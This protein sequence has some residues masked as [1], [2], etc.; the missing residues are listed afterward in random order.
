M[1]KQGKKQRAARKNKKKPKKREACFDMN[2][3]EP[4]RNCNPKLNVTDLGS[5]SN[6]CEKN[7]ES[8][9]DDD[10]NQLKR[11]QNN[12]KVISDQSGGSEEVHNHQNESAKEL[13]VPANISNDHSANKKGLRPKMRTFQNEELGELSDY[14]SPGTDLVKYILKRRF[15]SA[16]DLPT[17]DHFIFLQL[18]NEELKFRFQNCLR[19]ICMVSYEY[20]VQAC[21]HKYLIYY[22]S[23]SEIAN[24]PSANCA[25]HT[26]WSNLCGS[27]SWNG[28]LLWKTRIVS[29]HQITAQVLSTASQLKMKQLFKEFQISTLI[30][31]CYQGCDLINSASKGPHHETKG[32]FFVSET[33]DLRSKRN[34][35]ENKFILLRFL[36]FFK[37][38]KKVLHTESA[39]KNKCSPQIDNDL[40]KMNNATTPT[41]KLELQSSHHE[42]AVLNKG[43]SKNRKLTSHSQKIN[44]TCSLPCLSSCNNQVLLEPDTFHYNIQQPHIV[45]GRMSMKP[46][47]ARTAQENAS[48]DDLPP[49]AQCS[50]KIACGKRPQ[51]THGISPVPPTNVPAARTST[52]SESSCE[53]LSDEKYEMGVTSSKNICDRY[54]EMKRKISPTLFEVSHEPAVSTTAGQPSRMP[55]T[56]TAYVSLDMEDNVCFSTSPAL[57][58]RNSCN[59]SATLE[60][61][62]DIGKASSTEASSMAPQDLPFPCKTTQSVPTMPSACGRQKKC[63]RSEDTD[64]DFTIRHKNKLCCSLL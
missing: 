33:G 17:V 12:I 38:P 41:S 36:N 34:K 16:K 56:E 27:N 4:D 60:Q 40:S 50:Q 9:C 59:S 48:S 55:A 42:S 35:T 62:T 3:K 58:G 49:N 2:S 22:F 23:N 45:S 64:S 7:Y 31:S 32:Y 19:S 21:P 11:E 24:V 29:L 57:R 53:V 51:P 28:S 54:L 13:E 39:E 10:A 1:K 61:S 52:M 43:Y 47:V 14:D 5:A 18:G 15:I 46:P 30:Q 8:G 63:E 44:E 26:K 37:G 20:L 6:L 25:A